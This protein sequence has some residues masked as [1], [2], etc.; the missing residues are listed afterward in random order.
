VVSGRTFEFPVQSAEFEHG[1]VV[2][3]GRP[4]TKR[5]WRNLVEP[6]GVDVLRDGRWNHGDGVLLRPDDA[7]YSSAVAAYRLRWPRATLPDATLV[8]QVRIDAPARAR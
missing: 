8:V 6:A 7:G 3:P 1:I 2:V 5:W 4:E